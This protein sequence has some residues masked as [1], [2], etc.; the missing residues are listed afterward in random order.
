MNSWA[1][2]RDRLAWEEIKAAG[3]T[4][5]KED[6]FLAG[7]KGQREDFAKIL[8]EQDVVLVEGESYFRVRCGH[9]ADLFFAAGIIP[10]VTFVPHVLVDNHP[11]NE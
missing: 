11:E 7:R 9:M 6:T 10:R 5:G 8:M 2:E 3:L 1:L 4:Q